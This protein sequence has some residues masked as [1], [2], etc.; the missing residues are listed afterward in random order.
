MNDIVIIAAGIA[1]AVWICL[2]LWAIGWFF[3]FIVMPRVFDWLYERKTRP[4]K[5]D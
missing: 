2:L 5:E 4:F 1:L 3:I